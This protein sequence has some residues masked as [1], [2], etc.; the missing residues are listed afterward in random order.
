M[1]FKQQS[2][3][4]PTGSAGI[5]GFSSDMKISGV[6]IEPKFLVIAATLIV[7]AVKIADALSGY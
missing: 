3:S 7:M 4:M 5:V 2:V 1:S 6:E